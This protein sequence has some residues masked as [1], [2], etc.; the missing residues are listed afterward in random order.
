MLLKDPKVVAG[1]SFNFRTNLRAR[2]DRESMGDWL[3]AIICDACTGGGKATADAMEEAR[4]VVENRGTAPE[5]RARAA[6]QQRLQVDF[7][8]VWMLCILLYWA[9]CG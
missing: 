9:C 4:L 2:V 1:D 8:V 5:V 7:F 3:E 6:E